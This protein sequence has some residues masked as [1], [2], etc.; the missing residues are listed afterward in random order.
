VGCREARRD[1]IVGRPSGRVV[2]EVGDE[3]GRSCFTQQLG[4]HDTDTAGT[5]ADH[6][7]LAGQVEEL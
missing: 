6:C 5:A 1:E 2:V 3:D 7:H 4:V